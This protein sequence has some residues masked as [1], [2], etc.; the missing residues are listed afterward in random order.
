MTYRPDPSAER[1]SPTYHP[2]RDRLVRIAR[3]RRTLLDLAGEPGSI[4]DEEARR[5]AVD[6]IRLIGGRHGRRSASSGP[7]AYYERI[8]ANGWLRVCAERMPYDFPEL[9]ALEQELDRR[10]GRR[11]GHAAAMTDTTPRTG[12]KEQVQ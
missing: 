9:G 6:A 7:L 4:P 2:D 10:R 5:R 3:C 1:I 8:C 11:A 12:G